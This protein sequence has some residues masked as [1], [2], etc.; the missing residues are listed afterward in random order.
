M[1]DLNPNSNPSQKLW[2]LIQTLAQKQQEQF[3][4]NP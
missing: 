1:T 3:E 4:F 2:T